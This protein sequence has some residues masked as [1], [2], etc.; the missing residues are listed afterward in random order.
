MRNSAT[1]NQEESGGARERHNVLRPIIFGLSC[2][3]LPAVMIDL[4]LLS[5]PYANALGVTLACLIYF[6][7]APRSRRSLRQLALMILVF[8]PSAYIVG[9]LLHRN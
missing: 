1:D 5:R 3:T 8:A 2:V 7:V 4:Q 6:F 9:M